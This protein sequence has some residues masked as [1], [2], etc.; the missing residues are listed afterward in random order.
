MKK[1]YYIGGSPCSGKSI[2]AEHLVNKYNLYYFKVE[3]HL[4][5]Y[6]KKGVNKNLPFCLK[7]GKTNQ[8]ETWMKDRVLQAKE[9]MLF[10][11]EIFPF[12]LEDL[13]KIETDQ[14]I[15]AEGTAFLPE[16]I[17]QH[18]ISR[19]K[20]L[21]ITPCREFQTNHVRSRNWFDSSVDARSKDD[22][23]LDKWLDRDCYFANEVNLACKKTGYKS[24]MNDSEKTMEELID[25]VSK[26]FGLMK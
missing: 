17:K 10:Y 23:T 9:E 12:I 3:D 25:I 4:E 18:K 19:K 26:H 21:S 8:K 16:L 7:Q 6:T 15:V 5:E 22:G 13:S 11:K 20:Y 2:V 24:I 14:D 1:I